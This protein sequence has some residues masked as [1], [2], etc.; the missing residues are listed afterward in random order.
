RES[1][2]AAAGQAQGNDGVDP[3]VLVARDHS[4]HQLLQNLAAVVEAVLIA[5][6]EQ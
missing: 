4:G 1:T 3:A 6:N 5:S 2:T